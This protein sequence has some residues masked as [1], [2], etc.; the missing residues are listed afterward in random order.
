MDKAIRYVL[1]LFV[2]LFEDRRVVGLKN[3]V[4]H[5]LEM[6]LSFQN[7]FVYTVCYIKCV[8]LFSRAFFVAS[9]VVF[10][11]NTTSVNSWFR[12]GVVAC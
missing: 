5:Q 4:V 1:F 8:A 9:S 11:N 10:N 7:I 12:R 6:L 3:F 2:V